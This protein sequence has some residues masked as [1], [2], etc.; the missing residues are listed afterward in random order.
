VDWIH[1]AQGRDQWP[2]LMRT[3]MNFR[4]PQKMENLST[5]QL[6]ASQGLCS[7]EL[8]SYERLSSVLL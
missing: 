2:A 6:L 1:L 3:V 4:V 7:T 8:F 5:E